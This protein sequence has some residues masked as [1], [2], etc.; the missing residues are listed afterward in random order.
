MQLK[1]KTKQRQ[2]KN[3]LFS[4]PFLNNKKKILSQ[5][6]KHIKRLWTQR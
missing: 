4:Q 6:G 5:L 2:K 1:T 3:F